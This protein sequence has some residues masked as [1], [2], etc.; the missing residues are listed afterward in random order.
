MDFLIDT[1]AL[2]DHM[3][4]LRPLFSDPDTLKVQNTFSCLGLGQLGV[5]LKY[6]ATESCSC[7]DC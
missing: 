5:Q 2:H 4:L 7:V 1:L 3:D 6:V